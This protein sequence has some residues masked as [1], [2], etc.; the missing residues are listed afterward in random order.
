MAE[1]TRSKKT[2]WLVGTPSATF[3]NSKLPSKGDVLKYLFFKHIECKKTLPV[4]AK[5][6]AESVANIWNEELIPTKHA[7]D[8][9]HHVRKLH[10]RW[11]GL[12]KSINRKSASNTTK[13]MEFQEELQDLFDVAHQ[14]ALSLMKIEEDKAFLLA[15]R[16]KGRKGCIGRIDSKLLIYRR[17]TRTIRSKWM[18]NEV[19]D[20]KRRK[21]QRA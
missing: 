16:E 15:Q 12:K 6:T 19:N 3:P 14:D 21:Q 17:K 5:E 4:S 7:P 10:E 11:I 8:I 18:Q 13:Q 9:V 1:G 2:V 20:Q